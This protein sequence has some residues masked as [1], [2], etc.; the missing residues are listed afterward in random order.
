MVDLYKEKQ[1]HSISSFQLPFWDIASVMS[2]VSNPS[3]WTSSSCPLLK[4][5]QWA[6]LSMKPFPNPPAPR[7]SL[8]DSP[9]RTVLPLLGPICLSSGFYLNRNCVFVGFIPL[10]SLY[11]RLQQ[12]WSFLSCNLHCPEQALA[13]EQLQVIS[14]SSEVSGHLLCTSSVT[15]STSYFD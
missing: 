9:A 6:S 5:Y 2:Y 4:A 13:T 12:V 1:L 3:F 10:V 15:L 11:I 14:A 8:A 7:L